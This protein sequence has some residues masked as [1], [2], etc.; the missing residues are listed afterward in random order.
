LRSQVEVLFKEA[1]SRPEL[2]TLLREK[3]FFEV[4]N[5]ADD[6]APVTVALSELKKDSAIQR[7]LRQ[8][9]RD[10]QGPFAPMPL[11]LSIAFLD[12]KIVHGNEAAFCSKT[13]LA[14]RYLRIW[15]A[16][17][18]SAILVRAVHAKPCAPGHVERVYISR[19][20]ADSFMSPGSGQPAA[21]TA[22]VPVQALVEV[23]LHQPPEP[24]LPVQQLQ[25][26]QSS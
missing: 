24:E 25:S 20:F 3:R 17:N 6:V 5:D 18:L 9:A 10:Q 14:N 23:Y 7:E 11:T 2:R 4:S 26:G 12:E 15:R 21:A 16:D 8:L 13:D 1:G 19:E 22:P